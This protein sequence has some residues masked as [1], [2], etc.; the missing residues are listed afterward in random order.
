MRLAT[1]LGLAGHVGND[2]EGVFIEVEGGAGDLA[3]FA[4]RLTSDAPP[5]AQ[6]FGVE[7]VPGDATSRPRLPDRREPRR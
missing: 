5:M 6:I 2:P 3:V 7:S 4:A 1:E